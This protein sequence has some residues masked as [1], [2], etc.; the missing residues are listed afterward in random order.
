M[1]YLEV[2]GAARKS[3][4]VLTPALAA[5]WVERGAD[6]L[7]GAEGHANDNDDARNYDRDGGDDGGT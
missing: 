1:R 5:T 6:P 7:R 3:A 2:H 4:A